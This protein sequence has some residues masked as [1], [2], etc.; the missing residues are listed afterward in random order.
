MGEEVKGRFVEA[1]HKEIER[2]LEE[3]PW[4]EI[5]TMGREKEDA[6]VRRY[7][8]VA[9]LTGLGMVRLADVCKR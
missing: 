6:D 1:V 2:L 9:V 7:R 5:G 8:S 3:R 4:E